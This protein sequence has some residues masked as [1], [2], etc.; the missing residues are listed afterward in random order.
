M[1]MIARGVML[2]LQA[3]P[4]LAGLCD[5]GLW[6][7][8]IRREGPNA[9]PG[10][11]QDTDPYLPK[12]SCAVIDGGET[13]ELN[14]PGCSIGSLTLWFRHQDTPQATEKARQAMDRAAVLLNQQVISDPVTNN[15]GMIELSD[16]FQSQQDPWTERGRVSYLRFRIAGVAVGGFVG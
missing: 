1:A 8:P 13:P 16:R 7:R 11:F 3:D 12:L 6:D 9:T 5:G 14:R 2:F 10:A 4:T 15:T